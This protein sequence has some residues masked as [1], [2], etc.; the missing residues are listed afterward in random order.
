MARAAAKCR[1]PA[2]VRAADDA[3]LTAIAALVIGDHDRGRQV[4]GSIMVP[5][6]QPMP[7]PAHTAPAS[8]LGP[9]RWAL[10]AVMTAAAGIGHGAATPAPQPASRPAGTD[11]GIVMPSGWPES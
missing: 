9:V 11:N 1:H 2:M 5:R 10:A 8:A 6:M 3:M 4:T 7:I